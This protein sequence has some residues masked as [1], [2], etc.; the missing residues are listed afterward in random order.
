MGEK[1]FSKP[2]GSIKYPEK[3]LKASEYKHKI[4]HYK[5]GT[6]AC[7]DLDVVTLNDDETIVILEI[8]EF[9][10]DG[11]I[12]IPNMQFKTLV[13]LASKPRV[14]VFIVGV[15][16][17]EPFDINDFVFY[18]NMEHLQVY[19]PLEQGLAGWQIRK[20]HMLNAP[21]DQFNEYIRGIRS[22][23]FEGVQYYI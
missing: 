2:N 5:N 18:V 6:P 12:Y 7:T 21:I 19:V 15:D 13:A 1:Q 23:K 16:R 8:K 14:Q 17:Y 20:E 9:N 4:I 10:I 3:Y 11:T 22:S